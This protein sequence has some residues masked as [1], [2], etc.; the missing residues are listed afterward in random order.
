M[1]SF[2]PLH[3]PPATAPGPGTARQ[4]RFHPMRPDAPGRQGADPP[5]WRR[6]P[7]ALVDGMC[8]CD[9]A[10]CLMACAFDSTKTSWFKA[11]SKH[12]LFKSAS[13]DHLIFVF[14]CLSLSLS[15]F[16]LDRGIP[17]FV[18]D[19]IWFQVF[20]GPLLG[21]TLAFLFMSSSRWK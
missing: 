1:N 18:L 11:C 5:E 20:L 4:R 16:V 3:G 17:C 10:V 12:V 21:G 2:A 14:F 19:S 6:G 13:Y 15:R 8:E 7:I 9:P